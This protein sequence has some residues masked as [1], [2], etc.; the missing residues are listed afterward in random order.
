M[1]LVIGT[2]LASM[3]NTEH[4]KPTVLSVK[5]KEGLMLLHLSL[6]KIRDFGREA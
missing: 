2:A 4:S 3:C 5:A 6:N 1:R